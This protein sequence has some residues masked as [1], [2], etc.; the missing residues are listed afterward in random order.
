MTNAAITP[1][2]AAPAPPGWQQNGWQQKLRRIRR[3]HL[4]IA[5]LCLA[6]IAILL[7]AG[8]SSNDQPLDPQSASPSGSKALAQLLQ[9]E[10]VR[11]TKTRSLQEVLTLGSDTTV[12][13]LLPAVLPPEQVD[14]LAASRADLVLLQPDGPSLQLAA[15]LTM[16]LASPPLLRLSYDPGPCTLEAAVRAGDVE[17]GQAVGYLSETPTPSNLA[18][19]QC[20]SL[21]EASSQGGNAYLVTQLRHGERSV[22]VLGSPDLLTN[23]GLARKGNASLAMNLLGANPHLVWYLPEIPFG[24]GD[25]ALVDLLPA[26]V[27][28]GM[29]ALLVAAVVLALVRGRRLGPVVIEP[30]P[31][32]VRAAETAEGRARLYQRGK[33]RGRAAQALRSQARARLRRRYQLGRRDDPAALVTALALH[34]PDLPPDQARLLVEGPEPTSDEQLVEL[35]LTLDRLAGPS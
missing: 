11:S 23:D 5:A 13:V 4:I 26:G 25:A 2:Q 19:A 35:A 7:L 6:A 15:G 1:V 14:Q 31:V 24:A 12:L 34:Q 17:V 28:F 21:G 33:S 32:V 16:G 29:L 20:Y 8:G 9:A 18:I 30:L 22:T 3:A 10:G 27:R